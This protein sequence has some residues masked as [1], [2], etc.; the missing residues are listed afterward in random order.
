MTAPAFSRPGLGRRLASMLYETLLAG[1]VALVGLFIPQFVLGNVL[2]ALPGRN[3]TQAS[4]FLIL[5]IYFAWFWLHGGQTLAM[6]TWHLRLV[7]QDDRPI[8]PLQAIL[9]FFFA[10]PSLLLG[11]IGLWWALVDK[12]GLFLHDRLAGT[13]LRQEAPAPKPAKK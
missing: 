6:K 11:G 10:W 5:L 9:R 4:A 2:H 1:A 8:Q 3:I 12:E 7:R 13:K